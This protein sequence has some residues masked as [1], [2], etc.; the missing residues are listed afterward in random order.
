MPSGKR[1]HIVIVGAGFG[2]LNA[3]KALRKA[4]ADVTLI[5]KTNHHLFQPLLY[6]VATAALSPGDIAQPVRS[7]LRNASN[8][9]VVMSTVTDIDLVNSTLM[10][11]DGKFSYDAL[12]LAPGT[13]HAYFGH[14]EW[15]TIAPGLKNLE[16]ALR[17]RER[18]LATFEEAE[19]VIGTPLLAPLL[20]FV[21]VGGGPT[22]VELAGAISEIA[23]RTMLPDFPKLRRRD[24]TIVLLEGGSRLL[25]SF[26]ATLSNRA[27]LD[28]EKLGATVRL[29]TLVTH[30]DENGVTLS[31]RTAIRSRNVIWAAGNA[32][33]PIIAMAGIVCDKQGR[34][35]VQSDCSIPGRDNVFVI[36]DASHFVNEDGSLLPGV[37]QV[38]IQQGSFVA[39]LLG[40]YH[41][42]TVR[43]RF[44]YNDKG[45]MATIGRAKAVA[46]VK[47]LK[48]RGFI[49]WM[50][51]AVIHITFLIGF[52]NR[53]KV[54]VEWLWYYISFQPG[55]RLITRPGMDKEVR[56]WLARQPKT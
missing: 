38:A 4:D 18:M 17:I 34:A 23:L 36:G 53:I 30:V 16:D 54:M 56:A 48:L 37:A 7:T 2:G 26:D 43:P 33:S 27:K 42:T 1:R 51:W 15:E 19:N 52:R 41:A 32:A 6:Q 14:D 10:C 55:A 35:I 49:A 9:H 22:G 11:D 12:I 31:D 50:M 47:G 44:M 45:S 5:D 24:I 21:V 13:R 40:K 46:E 29:N 8:V 25:P 28:L 20:T 39:R 3:A